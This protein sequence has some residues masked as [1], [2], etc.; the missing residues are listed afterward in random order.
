MARKT[1][2]EIIDSCPVPREVADEVRLLKERTG[3]TLSSCDRSP[4][5]EPLLRRHKKKSQRQ[6]YEGWQKRLKGYNP[7]NP[8]G[9]S[10]HE[11]RNDGAAYPV[12][13]GAKLEDWQVGMDW[14]P[15]QPV[16]REA[17]RRG[18]VVTVTYPTDSREAHHLNFRKGP[19]FEVDLKRGDKGPRVEELT[20]KLARLRSPKTTEP[21][22]D[23]RHVAFDKWVV[24]AVKHFQEDYHQKVDG[25]YGSQTATQLE[26]ALREQKQREARDYRNGDKGP[27]VERLTKAL[28][29]LSDKDGKPYVKKAKERFDRFVE[30]AVKRFQADHRLKDDGVFGLKTRRKLYRALQKHEE[31][32]VKERAKA[33]AVAAKAKAKKGK[34]KK[35]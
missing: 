4:E 15:P 16:V 2:F 28:A 10:T 17:S 12:R 1:E 34:R 33:E 35:G 9:F 25:K 23:H 14:N 24:A 30:A 8:P 18:W 6:L 27:E 5:A 3:S 31:K 7:A 20:E 26:V 11:R 19:E 21:Y 22:L 29:I 13:R 32:L